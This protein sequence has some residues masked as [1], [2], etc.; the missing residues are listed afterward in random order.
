MI[1]G[2]D[3]LYLDYYN[4]NEGHPLYIDLLNNIESH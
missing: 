1:N 3:S 2:V 4:L